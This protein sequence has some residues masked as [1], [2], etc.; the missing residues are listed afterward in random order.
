MLSE[1]N[2]EL[3]TNAIAAK[4]EQGE[5]FF[6]RGIK[7]YAGISFVA[8]QDAEVGNDLVC[9]V[10]FI[11]GA[12]DTGRVHRDCRFKGVEILGQELS[13]FNFG[14]L[15]GFTRRIDKQIAFHTV[16]ECNEYGKKFIEE[17]REKI[18]KASDERDNALIDNALL[19]VLID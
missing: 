12:D 19:M 7:C 16:K 9:E 11:I 3:I 14:V 18:I 6:I 5:T 4:C 10:S 1:M 2:R 17:T 13:C 8:Q 15:E